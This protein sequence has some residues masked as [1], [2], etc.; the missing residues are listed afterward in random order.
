MIVCACPRPPHI[1][2]QQ[3]PPCRRLLPLLLSFLYSS[4]SSQASDIISRTRSHT[5]SPPSRC[6]PFPGVAPAAMDPPPLR[7]RRV[8]L[9]LGVPPR[10][11]LLRHLLNRLGQRRHLPPPPALALRPPPTPWRSCP[12]FFRGAGSL[13]LATPL[14]DSDWFLCLFFCGGDL[15]SRQRRGEGVRERERKR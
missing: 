4:P 1:T 10:L 12:W 13:C 7:G 15:T 9:R 14:S 5:S 6:R 3:H 2:A 8:R 11:P